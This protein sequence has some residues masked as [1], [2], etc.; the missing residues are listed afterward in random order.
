MPDWL[1][2]L[3]M[4]L[5]ALSAPTAG[6]R[7]SHY[8]IDKRKSH[9]NL[10]AMTNLLFPNR[11]RASEGMFPGGRGLL[12]GA[13]LGRGLVTTHPPSA[14][15]KVVCVTCSGMQ[16]CPALN[17]LR[18]EEVYLPNNLEEKGTCVVLDELGARM[19]SAVFG[20]GRTFRD[21]A[22]CKDIV[23]QY[24]CLF[25]GRNNNM[26]Q[27]WCQFREDVSSANPAE[28]QVAPR[29]PCRAFCVQVAKF[30]ANDPL[31]IQLCESIAC[32]PT[33]DDCTPNPTVH[34][35]MGK[36]QDLAQ[37]LG[38][39]MPYDADPYSPKN[40][41]QRGAG[42]DVQASLFLSTSLALLLALSLGLRR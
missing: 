31:F 17:G 41:A 26:Y 34:D 29:Y 40:S 16:F 27:N 3:L 10:V 32:P 4:V 28:H 15:S 12:E 37:N 38:C 22:Q 8:A 6:Q 35:A 24:L 9:E 23:M 14:T 11:S 33:E 1:A 21:T 42:R 19:F 39:N 25:Y 7:H 36:G 18:I 30:C 2:L 20:P 13:G 5:L